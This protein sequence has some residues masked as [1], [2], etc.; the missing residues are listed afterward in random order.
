[1]SEDKDDDEVEKLKAILLSRLDDRLTDFL[2][3]NYKE[4]KEIR[5]FQSKKRFTNIFTKI[6]QL[7]GVWLWAD[8]EIVDGTVEAY[9]NIPDKLPGEVQT[10]VTVCRFEKIKFCIFVVCL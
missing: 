3:L 2:S 7:I 4:V 5:W 9:D 8:W 6:A 10:A 1:M